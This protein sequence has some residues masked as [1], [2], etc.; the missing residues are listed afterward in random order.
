M[1]SITTT[2]SPDTFHPLK[3]IFFPALQTVAGVKS[4]MSFHNF[5]FTDTSNALQS[6][7]VLYT[8]CTCHCLS[9]VM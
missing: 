5:V 2:H 7:D 4:P 9:A 1:T 3:C 8:E 6:V